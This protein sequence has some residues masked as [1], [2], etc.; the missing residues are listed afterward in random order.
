MID[1]RRGGASR[2]EVDA[3]RLIAI[4]MNHWDNKAVNQRLLCVDAKSENCSH[5][6]VMIHDVGSDFGRRK[7]NLKEWAETRIWAN[8]STCTVSMKELPWGG[9]TFS[10]V[11]I[12][13]EGRRL[14]G[15]RLAQLSTAQISGL[16]T[17]AGFPDA[18]GWVAAFEEKVRQVSAPAHCPASASS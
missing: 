4:F 12:S 3:L 15:D 16:F 2:A 8:E 1:S 17:A 13:E 5:P 7:M 11:R 10:D 18:Q 6:L 14:L 9:G